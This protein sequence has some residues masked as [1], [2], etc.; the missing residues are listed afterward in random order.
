MN[1]RQGRKRRAQSYFDLLAFLAP[2]QN[3]VLHTGHRHFKVFML[4]R[5]LH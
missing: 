1:H 5:G 2:K 4:L 3:N